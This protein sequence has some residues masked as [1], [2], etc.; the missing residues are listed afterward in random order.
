MMNVKADH[1]KK[2]NFLFLP[3][4]YKV[5][6]GGRGSAKS[7]SFA[8]AL[9]I[10]G[11]K[12][13]LRILCAREVQESIKQSVHKLLSDQISKLGLGS[14]YTIT[15]DA[16]RGANGTE[17]AF[18][19]LSTLTVETIKSYEGVDIC[20]VEEGQTI[21][22]QSWDILIPTI[23]KAGS[24]IWITYNPDLETDETHQ[25]FTIN[26]PRNCINVAMNW[27]DN[28]WW[29][30]LPELED[31]RQHCLATAPDDYPNIWEGECKAAVSGAIYHK[32][33]AAAERQGRICNIPYDPMLKVHVVVDLGWDDSLTAALVQVKT[34]E[35]RIIEYVEYSHTTLDAWSADLRTRPYNWGRVWLPPS[36]GF[37][38]S[39][40]SKGLSAYDILLA[41]RW[42]VAEKDEV[43][44][45]DVDAGI[46]N[47]R[48]KFPRFYFD[49]EKA[50]AKKAVKKDEVPDSL[51]GHTELSHRLVECI[52]R[53]RR[54]I[55]KQT[56][57]PGRPVR[58]IYAHG[59][60][61][62]RYIANNADNMLNEEEP[63]YSNASDFD[64]DGGGD[65]CEGWMAG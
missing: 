23:R 10:L 37:S 40:K 48:M 8:R 51:A 50:A 26:K 22:K 46:R 18:T 9:L 59:G 35:I 2:L 53:Y 7:W 25:R 20:W 27:R 64:Y 3:C 55:N 11:A 65:T 33:I 28:P 43:V 57:A 54:A 1:P 32:E 29:H 41:L 45:L 5:A 36:D 31:E 62:I 6:R 44:A 14:F 4:R 63:D 16:I 13:K 15:N 58:D 47:V 34:S 17:F 19:G 49:A 42:D 30:E 24:E 12:K 38:S 61:T 56:L 39:L 60:D 21:S 52:K